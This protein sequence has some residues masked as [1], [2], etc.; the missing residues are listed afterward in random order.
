MH[1]FPLVRHG[2]DRQI[3][4]TAGLAPPAPVDSPQ[5]GALKIYYHKKKNIY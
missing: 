4:P 2:F 1:R 5:V 3:S